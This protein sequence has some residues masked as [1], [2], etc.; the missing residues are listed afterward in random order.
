MTAIVAVVVQLAVM[1]AVLAWA[2]SQPAQGAVACP[3]TA[4][5]PVTCTYGKVII[6]DPASS[7][8]K[9]DP[10]QLEVLDKNGAPMFWVNVGGAWSGGEPV[11]VTNL[12]LRPVACIGGP[13]GSYGGQASITLY[14]RAGPVTITAH[15]LRRLLRLLNR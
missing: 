11:C 7:T 9:P 8:D 14:G 3:A 10:N 5:A 1:A 2:Y 12:R 13:A 4:A 6:Q 15:Q